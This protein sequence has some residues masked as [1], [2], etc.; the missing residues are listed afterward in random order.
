MEILMVFQVQFIIAE[1][2]EYHELYKIISNRLYITDRT[3]K[4]IS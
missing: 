2:T 1:N 4:K 3:L